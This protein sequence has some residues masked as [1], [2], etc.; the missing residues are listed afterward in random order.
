MR[1]IFSWKNEYVQ[2]LYHKFHISYTLLRIGPCFVSLFGITFISNWK[3]FIL[4][5]IRRQVYQ[6]QL[7][8]RGHYASGLQGITQTYI[9]RTKIKISNW[10]KLKSFVFINELQRNYDSISGS[11]NRTKIKSQHGQQ[12]LVSLLFKNAVLFFLLCWI[13]NFDFISIAFPLQTVDGLSDVDLSANSSS[14]GSFQW[15][16]FQLEVLHMCVR[17]RH[18]VGLFQNQFRT[19]KYESAIFDPTFWNCIFF[20]PSNIPAVKMEIKSDFCGHLVS[21]WAKYLERS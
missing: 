19:H 3:G 20:T 12:G 4:N 16:V 21:F 15:H 6:L 5:L 11:K 17:I 10:N 14:S 8:H 9:G 13:F 1:I 18:S 2:I 7:L